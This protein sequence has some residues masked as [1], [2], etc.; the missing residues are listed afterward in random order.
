[1]TAA[2]F[3]SLY[4]FFNDCKHEIEKL[5]PIWKR[6]RLKMSFQRMYTLQESQVFKECLPADNSHDQ[7]ALRLSLASLSDIPGVGEKVRKVLIDHF[8]TEAVALKVILDFR[9]DLVAAVPEIGA[10]QAVNIVKAAFE[11]QFGASANTIL[12]SA[13]LRKIFDSI[14]GIIRGYANTSYA[15]DKL[16]LYFPLP[17]EKINVIHERQRYFA[18]AIDVAKRL[19]EDQRA[20]LKQQL[21]N[22]R[23]L[24]RRVKPRRL[25]G[26]VII[27]N[28]DK[29]FDRLVKEGID[30]WC[31]VYI[32]SEGENAIDYAKGYD[33]VL[34]I[35]PIGMYD[36]SVNMLDNVEILGK[37]WTIDE[38][39]PEMTIGFYSRNYRVIDASSRLAELFSNLPKNESVQAF[40]DSLDLDSLLQVGKAL[41]NIN[42]EGD[43]AQS[44]DKE[45]DRYRRAVKNF[46]TAVAETESW[47][48]EEIKARIAKSQITLGGQQIITILQSADMDGADSSALRNM[49]PAEIIETFTTT[50]QE[51]EDKLVDILGLT[52]READWVTGII[53]EEIALPVK[54]IPAQINDLEGRLRRFFSDRQ[55]RLIKKVSGQLDKLTDVVTEAVQTLLE[56]DLFLAVGLFGADYDLH[57]PNIGLEYSGIGVEQATNLFLKESMLRGRHRKVQPIDYVIGNSLFKPDGTNGENC[58]ILSG[59]NSGGKTTTIQTLA[60]IATMAQTGF[61]VP[62]ENA[63]LPPFEEIYFFYKSRGMVSAGAF[64]TTLKQFA[65][66][67]V[68]EKSKL[69]LFDEVEAI[70]EPGSAANVIAGLIEILQRDPHSCAVICSHLAKEIA[71]ATDVPIR[72]DGIEARGLDEN[73]ELMVD[74][75]PRFG[76]IARSTPELIVERLTKLSK[77]K[78]KEVY[79]KILENLLRQ[80][81]EM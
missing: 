62:A 47:L 55:F 33:L 30:K 80:R 61:P 37:D 68:S 44:I 39:L 23:G 65:D 63:Y 13:D 41:K 28:D 42:E 36:D 40:I 21:T 2:K 32:L 24:Y 35:S 20:S 52:P 81:K 43:V 4:V 45:L 56:F 25:E 29:V 71:A 11:Q 49:L 54:L 77:G 14:L 22:V 48:N 18:D 69:A 15:R 75:T 31:P 19:S 67:V 66:I 50:I 73:L 3:D 78:K 5:E 70:T 34:Y 53:S 76:T 74:R 10:K 59:A 79:E 46:P 57:I 8:G 64:E 27:T 72:I 6:M 7:E 16:L 12:R 38:V 51:A 17:P 26:R 60:Q 9:V 58:A 1:M